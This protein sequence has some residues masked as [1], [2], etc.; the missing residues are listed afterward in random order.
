MV[1]DAGFYYYNFEMEMELSP[2]SSR[3]NHVL[4][5]TYT[6]CQVHY[7]LEQLQENDHQETLW[8]YDIKEVSSSNL[9]T[10]RQLDDFTWIWK[11]QAGTGKQHTIP[12]RLAAEGL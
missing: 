9:R 1:N 7:E 4:D 3:H 12:L 11:K 5:F 8:F 2:S 6:K 10:F